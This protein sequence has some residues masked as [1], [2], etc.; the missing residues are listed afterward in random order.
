[1]HRSYTVQQDLPTPAAR[2]LV[3]AI[4]LGQQAPYSLHT[5]M[6]IKSVIRLAFLQSKII[7]KSYW[8]TSRA[9]FVCYMSIWKIVKYRVGFEASNAV[10][11][12][13]LAP[14]ASPPAYP[15]PMKTRVRHNQCNAT[16]WIGVMLPERQHYKRGHGTKRCRSWQYHKNASAPT[17]MFTRCIILTEC[18]C[19]KVCVPC[20]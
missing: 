12:E 2:V 8:R 19:Y 13:S 9:I 17:L 11:Q 7:L 6:N 10:G 1:M 4:P 20:D 3:Q 15:Q 16:A 14:Q 18:L 5:K